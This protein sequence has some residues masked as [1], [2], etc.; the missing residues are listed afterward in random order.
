[1]IALH[2]NTYL[3]ILIH[4][5]TNN[6]NIQSGYHININNWLFNIL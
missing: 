4:R 6:T 3:H 2:K 1:M 5:N